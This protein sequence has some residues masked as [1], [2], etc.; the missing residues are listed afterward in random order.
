MKA[1]VGGMDKIVRIVLGVV[2]IAA[3]ALG[4]GGLPWWVAII[5]LIPL[6]TALV[7]FCPLYTLIGVNTCPTSE[8]K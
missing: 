1:N 7:G 5:G 2:L 8:K 3:G 6:G 4:L